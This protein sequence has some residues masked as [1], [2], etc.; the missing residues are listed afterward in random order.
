MRCEHC[1]KKC[2]LI[3]CSYCKK[4]CCFSCIQLEVHKC[5]NIVEKCNKLRTTLEKSLPQVVNKKHDFTY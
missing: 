4:D 5:E 1:N 2:I 3:M